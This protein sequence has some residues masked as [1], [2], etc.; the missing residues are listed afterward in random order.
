MSHYDPPGLQPTIV[1]KGEGCVAQPRGIGPGWIQGK[2]KEKR[3]KVSFRTPVFGKSHHN[4]GDLRDAGGCS[5]REDRIPQ[6]E[7]ELHKTA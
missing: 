4:C 6:A 1:L 3:G 2:Y 7:K 5:G